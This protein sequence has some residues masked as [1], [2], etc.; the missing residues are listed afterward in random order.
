MR[1]L[2]P[3]VFAVLLAIVT[4]PGAGSSTPTP[5]GFGPSGCS[6]MAEGVEY[7]PMRRD[8]P[9]ANVYV[10]HVA[11]GSPIRVRVAKSNDHPPRRGSSL[12]PDPDKVVISVAPLA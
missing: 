11:P 8:S 12:V 5:P 4:V 7:V 2:G 6:T 1:K 3:I 9:A 10:G